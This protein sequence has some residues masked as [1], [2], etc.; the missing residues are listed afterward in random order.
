MVA[1]HRLDMG[2]PTEPVIL[3]VEQIED[4]SKKLSSFKHDINNH[5]ALITAAVEL[6]KVSPDSVERMTQTLSQQPAKITADVGSFSNALEQALG[7]AQC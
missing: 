6:I 5:L 3:S 1:R 7:L 4:L 2:R